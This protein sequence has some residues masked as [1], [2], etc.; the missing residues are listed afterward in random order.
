MSNRWWS[1]AEHFLDIAHRHDMRGLQPHVGT[2]Y[3]PRW[4]WDEAVREGQR[5]AKFG[6]LIM[7]I[8]AAVDP[9]LPADA[10]RVVQ[11]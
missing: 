4:F 2:V 11:P 8:R 6:T 10:L 3:V 9:A 1:F 5:I 7:G